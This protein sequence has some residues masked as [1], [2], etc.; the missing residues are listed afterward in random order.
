MVLGVLVVIPSPL[1]GVRGDFSLPPE[2]VSVPSPEALLLLTPCI[3]ASLF[4]STC[5]L[6][7]LLPII[8]VVGLRGDGKGIGGSWASHVLQNDPK[9]HLRTGRP[10]YHLGM[11]T[12]GP[13]GPGS[14]PNP[15]LTRR[16]S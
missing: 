2:V 4:G 13:D 5:H 12:P 1:T 10:E 3:K 15:S 8:T 11:R 7:A 16:A 9:L 14:I 6:G